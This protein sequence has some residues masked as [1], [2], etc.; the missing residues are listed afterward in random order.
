MRDYSNVYY[1]DPSNPEALALCVES[2]PDAVY[3]CVANDPECKV[4]CLDAGAYAPLSNHPDIYPP[5]A[6]ALCPTE[7][8]K[9]SDILGLGGRCVPSVDA[10]ESIVIGFFDEVNGVEKLQQVISDFG[11]AWRPMLYLMTG[12]FVI[13]LLVIVLMRCIVAPLIYGLILFGWLSLGVLTVFLFTTWRSLQDKWDATPDDRR[14]DEDERNLMFF[15]VTMVISLVIFVVVT[16]VLI[17]MRQR[18]RIAVTI[19]EEASAALAHMP[20]VR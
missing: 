3:S 12:A 4:I 6:A 7:T 15:K 8:Y 19:F 16:I 17:A 20:Q 10:I 9:S 13:A 14:Y 11:Y 5:D 18:I 2:C 1:F